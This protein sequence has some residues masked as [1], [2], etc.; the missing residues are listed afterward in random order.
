MH[1][2]PVRV[3]LVEADAAHA[4]AI[5]DALA[6]AGQGLFEMER[7]DRLAVALRRLEERAFD[8]ILLDLDLP[9]SEGFETFDRFHAAAPGAPVVVLS[10]V[11]DETVAAKTVRAG[12]QDYLV[13]GDL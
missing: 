11:D 13:K 3:L 2:S 12:A 8:V 9:D 6:T 7:V 1:D 5:R 4:N 10:R